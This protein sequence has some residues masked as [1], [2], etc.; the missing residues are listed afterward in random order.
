MY[1]WVRRQSSDI[2]DGVSTSLEA[3]HGDESAYC[4][5][6]AGDQGTVYGYART[7]YTTAFTV[8]SC[9]SPRRFVSG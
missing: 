5:Q 6:G 4:L 3:R 7:G 9:F 8:A 1:V 2:D